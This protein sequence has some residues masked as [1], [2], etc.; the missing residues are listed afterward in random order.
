MSEARQNNNKSAKVGVSPI[1]IMRKQPVISMQAPQL[2]S[3]ATL[4]AI[5][6]LTILTVTLA[7][8]LWRRTLN[9]RP[10]G[11]EIT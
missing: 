9:K 1:T 10:I 4:A 3:Q 11:P 7:L 2:S 8:I 5:S 6:L